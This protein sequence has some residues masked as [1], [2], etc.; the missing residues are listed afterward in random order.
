MADSKAIQFYGNGK[1]YTDPK[2][3]KSWISEVD[4]QRKT[5]NTGR[6]KD[7]VYKINLEAGGLLP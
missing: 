4:P 1:Q 7:M 6:P 3:I 5:R 2:T